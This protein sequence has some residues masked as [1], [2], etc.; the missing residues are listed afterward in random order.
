MNYKKIYNQLTERAK[1]RIKPDCY[2][3]IHH[4]IPRCLG[5]TDDSDNLV[6][7]TAREH[8]ICHWLLSRIYP[9]DSKISHSFWRMC[10]LGNSKQVRYTPSSRAI[11][12]ARERSIYFLTQSKIGIPRSEETK[13]KLSKANKGFKVTEETKK[14]ISESNKG[15]IVKEETRDK[16]RKANTGKKTNKPAWNRGIETPKETRKKISD[17][18]KGKVVS[19]ETKKKIHKT[20]LNN[21][22]YKRQSERL[23]GT[24][25]WNKGKTGVSEETSKKMSESR[26]GNNINHKKVICPYC[27]KSGGSNI[28]SRWHFDNCK[29]KPESNIS[30]SSL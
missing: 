17:A 18:N 16:I 19:E 12:E 26:K 11:A 23:K 20:K 3:E 29:H 28:M 6:V 9:E 15:R 4:I 13:K 27:N 25:P 8:F 5:G 22:V 2:T 7:L 30:L 10:S 14:K 1:E 24:E 21:G